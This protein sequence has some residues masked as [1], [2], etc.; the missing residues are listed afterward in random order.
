VRLPRLLRDSLIYGSGTLLLRATAFVTVPVYTRYFT[1]SEY[2]TW[3]FVATAVWFLNGF[4]ILGGDS[5]FAR[6]YF[7]TRDDGERR[8]LTSTLLLA[9]GAWSLAV[10]AVLLPFARDFSSWS[11]G[12]THD[13]E[14]FELALVAAPA[15]MVNAMASQA[16]R[17]A[18][19]VTA[20]SALNVASAA[21]E[22]GASLTFLIVADEGLRSPFLGI[23]VSA[24]ALLPVRL[25]LIRPL[26]RPSFSRRV[27][28][29]ALAYGVPL[30]PASV[31]MWV[32][33]ASDRLILAKLSSTAELGLY[34]VAL[35]AASLL[36]LAD[37]AFGQAWFPYAAHLYEEA[38]AAAPRVYGRVLKYV[39]VAFGFAALLVTVFAHA[40]LVLLSQ[41]EFY[42]GALGVGPL[43]IGAVGLVAAR[44]TSLGIVLSGR[45]AYVTVM[46]SLAAVLNVLLNLVLVPPYGFV[47]S[48]IATAIAYAAAAV[49]QMV[50]SERLLPV[51]EYDRRSLLSVVLLSVVLVTAAS[52]LNRFSPPHELLL[53]LGLVLLFP[54]A[55]LV[56]RPF[57]D[58]ERALGLA[59]VRWVRGAR[60]SGRTT[61]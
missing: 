9:L 40:I 14:L 25:W 10:V 48:A 18:F 26:L 27:L 31:S 38:P 21:L 1:P 41:P 30:V 20:A 29:R 7:Q 55:L 39:L 52:L 44:V 50:V 34:S 49:G 32:L 17:N 46:L 53:R 15:V 6:F 47:G 36:V 5:A 57:D 24:V 12:T 22:V 61:P 16:L 11:F 43:A 8:V 2:G 60:P 13:A 56:V 35:G 23:L 4:L 45:T 51:V 54:A 19:R 3:N 58:E 37:S 33:L 28:R 59:A 42:A